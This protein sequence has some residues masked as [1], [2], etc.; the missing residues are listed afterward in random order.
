MTEQ[1]GVNA[2]ATDLVISRLVRAPRA[3]LWQA[4]ADPKLLKEWWCPRPWTTEVREFDLRPG[5]AFYT[6]M[7]GP[8]GGTSDNPGAFLE[9]VPQ[10]RIVFTSMLTGG[11]RPNTPWLPFTAI[12]TMAD[13]ASGTRYV[14]TVMHP[15]SATRDKHDQMGFHEGWGICITQLDELALQLR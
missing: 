4:W 3:K 11:W 7:R 2:D 6:F 10:A 15:D 8:D 1:T 5:G 9:V 13:E 14:A 12:I